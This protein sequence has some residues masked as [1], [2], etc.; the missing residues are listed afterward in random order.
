MMLV[1]LT[2]V[3]GSVLPVAEFKDQLL[4]GTGFTDDGAQDAVLENYLRAAIAAIEARIGKVLVSKQYTWTVTAWRE[5]CRQT[6]PLAPVNMVDQLRIVDRTGGTSVVDPANYSLEQDTHRPKIWALGGSLP[7]IPIGGIS[8]IDFTAGYGVLWSDVPNDLGLS[9][10]L[11]ASHFYENR[12]ATGPRNDAIP[13]GV[14]TL[15]ERYRNVRILGGSA[16]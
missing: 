9:V 3:P 7:T 5:T 6:L 16:T 15:I 11:L 10:L 1:E 8:E 13:F 12:S 4:L 2:T 14:T